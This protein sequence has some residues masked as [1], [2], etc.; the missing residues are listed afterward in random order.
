MGP[1]RRV[2]TAEDSDLVQRAVEAFIQARGAQPD[3]EPS[4]FCGDFPAPLQQRIRERCRTFLDFDS[5]L[6]GLREDDG[7]DQREDGRP[8][9]EFVIQEELGRGGM[10][11]VYLAEQP[12]LRRRVALKVLSS[13]LALSSRHVERFRREAAVAARLRHRA[14]VPV[15]SFCEE[16][17]AYAFAMDFVAGRNLHDLLQDLRLQRQDNQPQAGA[18]LGLLPRRADDGAYLREC[19]LL[20]A[21]LAS[22][23][24]AAHEAGIAHRDLKPRNVMVDDRRQVRLLDF[25]LAK[26][27][28]QQGLTGSLDITGTVHYMSPE[29]TLQNKAPQDHRTDIF[30]L[31]V[32]LY[33]LLTLTRPFEGENLQQ[34]VYQICFREPTPIRARNPR[35]PRD[36]A[37]ICEKALE[38][39]PQRRYATAAELEDDL[40]RFLAFEP[41]RARPAGPM[42]RLMRLVQ[43]RRRAAA[44]IA[45]AALAAL[46]LVGM[47]LQDGWR[48]RADAAARLLAAEEAA[49]AGSF[50][51][52]V[53][54]AT[55]AV[56]LQPDDDAVSRRLELWRERAELAATATQRNK[57]EAHVR[58][59]QSQ[60]LD[61]SQRRRA[62]ELCLEA[63]QLH[64]EPDTRGAMLTALRAGH[65]ALP[66]DGQRRA[67]TIA[68]S[69]DGAV[70]ATG[71]IDGPARLWDATTGRLLGELPSPDVGTDAA[72]SPDGRR[73][74]VC[75]R[76]GAA[77][78][79]T[80]DQR[81]L[82]RIG[83]KSQLHWLRFSP[84]GALLLGAEVYD[85]KRQ[86]LAVL[87][88]D[89][90]T[91]KEL[92]R[93]VTP[94]WSKA[95]GLTDDGQFVVST[96][97]PGSAQIWRAR[98][99]ETVARLPIPGRVAALHL[100][101][102]REDGG[103]RSCNRLVALATDEGLCRV[104]TVPDGRLVAEAR[105]SDAIFAVQ[106]SPDGQRLLTASADRTARLWRLPSA[107]SPRA[108]KVEDAAAMTPSAAA[109]QAL[110]C[111]EE[112]VLLGHREAVLT[113]RFDRQGGRVVS[114]C[115]GGVLLVT[116]ADSGTELLR[117]ENPGAIHHAFFSAGGER[118]CLEHSGTA[119]LALL[120]DEPRGLVELRHGQIASAGA[121]VD[122]R[123]EIVTASGHSLQT[124]TVWDRRGR[125]RRVFTGLSDGSTPESL[126]VDAEGRRVVV[127][128]LSG[129]A[130]V[131]DL[132]S[133]VRI[134]ESERIGPPV[135]FAA[136]F[137]DGKTCLIAGSEDDKA[138]I[139]DAETGA[140]QRSLP[141]PFRLEC[142][143]LSP[144]GS[145][146]AVGAEQ[147]GRIEV[148]STADG[149]LVQ[150]LPKHDQAV[151]MLQFCDGGKAVASCAGDGTAR[152][153]GL[154]GRV[155]VRC[156][157]G[158][159]LVRVAVTD[160][161]RRLVC[162]NGKS[163]A[164]R[165]YVF[166]ADTGDLLLRHGLHKAQVR[167]LALSRDGATALSCD[168][169]STV[170]VWPLDPVQV[171]RDLL[172]P[173]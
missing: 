88:W 21:E 169:E 32:I 114:G 46:T 10:G 148:R 78:Y 81:E 113:A 122:G 97:E 24:A 133:G 53:Q 171:A 54:L 43:R 130:G 3:L 63:V 42:L 77:V 91:G 140:L 36:L 116:D 23:L 143:A 164:A 154:D 137:P 18:T 135:E 124:L 138:W 127:G 147:D 61:G 112:R 120:L 51:A 139:L 118:V 159:P 98:T 151:R 70:V 52:A 104:Y 144:D 134:A 60:Q 167:H 65:R 129:R 142:V 35:V 150:A 95:N 75:G 111:E 105:H 74:A 33:E 69:P 45:A 152:I 93:M 158:E 31:G 162:C 6:G 87:C 102:V 16:D 34:I 79:A 89:A 99:G 103:G 161:G 62:I 72:F 39:D 128:G 157:A 165:I 85:L 141:L 108:A 59:L 160:D 1:Q 123:D 73:V 68:E 20:A 156:L 83:H 155:R 12:G 9:G 121:F 153:T 82:L 92:A 145:L 94:R 29:Q 4:Q 106:F 149:S 30:S 41:I 27:F 101:P 170:R 49:A 146:F 22:A 8:F 13:G 71:S 56:R 86:D 109:A 132:Q 55:E 7:L 17:G 50:A 38:K 15:H 163:A 19:A 14:I 57:A 5:F 131:F 166:D 168:T 66:F 110:R 119:T 40:R 173:R 2:L 47:S 48:R 96:G 172:A 100:Q 125:S 117:Y 76:R 84:D 44:T 26:E 28:G 58:L 67:G 25:G 126:A 80:H 37:T 90:A 136:F 64:D 11:V 107:T 115:A